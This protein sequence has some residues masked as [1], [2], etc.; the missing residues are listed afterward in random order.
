MFFKKN[1]VLKLSIAMCL[2]IA[3]VFFLY[4]INNTIKMSTILIDLNHYIALDGDYKKV[5]ELNFK[6]YSRIY[7]TLPNNAGI[8]IKD[9]DFKITS[10]RLPKNEYEITANRSDI[11]VGTTVQVG[12][13]T[14]T[15][16]GLHYGV[17]YE[18]LFD[19]KAI[20]YFEN[21]EGLQL[22]AVSYLK[23]DSVSK[24]LTSL[25]D[26]SKITM[27]EKLNFMEILTDMPIIGAIIVYLIFTLLPIPVGV[28]Y[29]VSKYKKNI[30]VYKFLGYTEMEIFSKILKIYAISILLITLLANLI[31]LTLERL[32]FNGIISVFGSYQMTILNYIMCDL[33]FAF[34][35]FVF[36]MPIISQI[37]AMK[38]EYNDE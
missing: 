9:D 32:W 7:I 6:N 36:M 12:D 25:F 4:I 14:F 10:G 29:L 24:E 34:L 35:I 19:Y 23:L 31:Y 8:K 37:K 15:V 38:A 17:E 20:N 30:T 3:L 28:Q 26:E 21:K 11:N 16:V 1:K 18:L 27:P 13:S 2:V 33:F 22:R 5:E